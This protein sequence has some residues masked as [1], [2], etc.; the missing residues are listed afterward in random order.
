MVQVNGN[1]DFQRE[2]SKKMR[3]FGEDE[4]KGKWNLNMLM[5]RTEIRVQAF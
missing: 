1:Y 5:V 2:S 3:E 4:P